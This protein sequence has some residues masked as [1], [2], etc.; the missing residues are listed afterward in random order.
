VYNQIRQAY[1]DI[2]IS[3]PKVNETS[4]LGLASKVKNSF[5][6]K[7][8]EDKVN[9]ISHITKETLEELYVSWGHVTINYQ[10]L[11][12]PTLKY[13][14]DFQTHAKKIGKSYSKFIDDMTDG[15]VVC[16]FSAACWGEEALDAI[17]FWRKGD[18][19]VLKYQLYG[20]VKYY[21]EYINFYKNR[22]NYILDWFIPATLKFLEKYPE[23]IGRFYAKLI[24]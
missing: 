7:T 5:A 12:F 4:N 24:K 8:E 22:K 3:E 19:K 9:N 2:Q 11:K 23:Y 14:R 21:T 10:D 15:E 13:L 17:E 1:P 16:R 20:E 6:E 18:R